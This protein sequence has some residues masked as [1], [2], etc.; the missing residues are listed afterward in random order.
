MILN[1][2]DSKD[3][4]VLLKNDFGR[5]I[6]TEGFGSKCTEVVNLLLEHDSASEDR[7]LGGGKEIPDEEM[8]DGSDVNMSDSAQNNL[9]SS[10]DVDVDIDQ[11]IGVDSHQNATD[12]DC[13]NSVNTSSTSSNGI[14]HE[15]DFLRDGSVTDNGVDDNIINHDET[16]QDPSTPSLLVRELPITN[17]DN[18]FGEKSD[19]D[20]TGL[21]I[22]CASL[23]MARWMA[24]KSI[25]GRFDH[26][27]KL[28]ELGAGCGV[29]GLTAA[30]YSNAETIYMTDLNPITV[31]N[32][33]YNVD[34][35]SNRSCTSSNS[36]R[37]EWHERVKVLK[38][39]WGDESTWPT[40]KID[41]ILGSDL[42]YQK[43]IVPLL[44]KVVNG[45][46]NDDGYF[47]YVCPTDG[48]DGL[49]EFITS[50]KQDGFKCVSEEIA[51]DL[52]R[53]NPLKSGDADDAFLHFYELPVTEYKLYEFRR[54]GKKSS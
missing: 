41:V 1:H 4:D 36:V 10:A 2:Y 34:L 50:M 27:V 45:L 30:L 51:P 52:Y 12:I 14:T 20:T 39:D 28:L 42:I 44:K 49:K 47:L 7:L 11:M 8:G 19:D 22:W 33:Q 53:S 9:K 13:S 25:L 3:I 29:P 26:N 35:N 40:E 54:N 48:R 43:S 5:S 31:R 38:M 21:G 15:F 23:V 17:A 16:M 6:L 37:G 46:V 18:P 32:L 24:S